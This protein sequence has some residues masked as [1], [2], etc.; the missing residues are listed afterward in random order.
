MENVLPDEAPGSGLDSEEPINEANSNM[1]KEHNNLIY[2][3]DHFERGST[4]V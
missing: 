3:R 2:D 4:L 1:G